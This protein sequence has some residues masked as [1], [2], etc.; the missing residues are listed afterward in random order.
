MPSFLT[1]REKFPHALSNQQSPSAAGHRHRL[2]PPCGQDPGSSETDPRGL[3]TVREDTMAPERGAATPAEGLCGCGMGLESLRTAIF[4]I[5]QGPIVLS[6][7][8]E[9]LFNF[10]F[11]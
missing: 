4:T 2:P 11:P 9:E 8:F 1:Q 3:P 7:Q 6:M 10:S 5:I